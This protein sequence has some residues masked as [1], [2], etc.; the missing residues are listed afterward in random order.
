M[1]ALFYG[2]DYGQ[3]ESV[4]GKIGEGADAAFAEHDVVVAFGEDVFGGHQEFVESGGHAALE[5]DGEFGAAGAF[6]ERKVLHVASADLDYVG[7][8]LDKVERFIVDGF[9]DDA[10]TELLAN[11]G[12]NFE[13]GETEA[14]EG[15]GRSA[16]FVRATPEEMDAGGLELLGDGETLL[17]GFDGAGA[18][19]HGDVFAADEDVTGRRGNFDDGIF[20]F[21]V[22]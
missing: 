7:V 13:A 1:A 20:F 10:E 3:V 4:A 22:A 9:G 8:F 12:E 15:V 6:E 18:G 17:F 11:F 5:E 14:L 19:N 21:Y 16:W 2:G